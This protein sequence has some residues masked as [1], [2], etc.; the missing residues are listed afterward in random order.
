VCWLL[1]AGLHAAQPCRYCSYSSSFRSYS[2][3]SVAVSTICRHSSRVVAFLQAVARPKFR[4][5]RSASIA[6]SQVWLGLPA[7][8][9]QL[10]GACRIHAAN[11]FTLC[12][13]I[14]FRPRGAT[15]GRHIAPINLQ[16][17]TGERSA[18]SVKFHVYQGR[19]VGNSR[20]LYASI[21]SFKFLIWLF[22][23]EKQPSYKDFTVVGTFMYFCIDTFWTR[24]D[25]CGCWSRSLFWKT[26]FLCNCFVHM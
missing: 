12:P 25:R 24:R 19:N 13:K 3:W 2:T 16:F 1:A 4:G 26:F 22:L 11:V 18:G 17:G 20:H 15:Q 9:F 5:P 14:G 7:G 6:R 10:G 8:R 21:G 23:G